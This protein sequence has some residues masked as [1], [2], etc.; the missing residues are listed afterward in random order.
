MKQWKL[1]PLVPTPEMIAA[2]AV[3]LDVLRDDRAKREAEA[4]R[5]WR[6]MYIAAP[7]WSATP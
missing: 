1:V 6:S 3:R 5:V 2:G 7:D 4:E